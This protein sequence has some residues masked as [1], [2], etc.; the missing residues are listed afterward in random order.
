MR[1]FDIFQ[2][3]GA[4]FVES[5][6][7]IASAK[8]ISI[9][10]AVKGVETSLAA[11]FDCQRIQQVL[12]NLITNALKYSTEGGAIM[13][14]AERRGN[15]IWFT[16]ADQGPGIPADRLEA[17]FDRFAQGSRPDRRGLGLGLYIARR[18]V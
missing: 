5:F 12:G 15:A 18:I 4:G 7:P 16:V 9:S 3:I 2:Q 1:P 6:G 8:G 11:H 14:C 13:V 17:I 10:M